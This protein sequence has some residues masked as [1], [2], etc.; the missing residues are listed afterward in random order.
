M[1]KRSLTESFNNAIEGL[2]YVVKTQRNMKIHLL[3]G[4]AVL[5]ISLFFNLTRLELVAI[6]FAIMLVIATELLNTAIEATIDM[7]TEDHH[8]FARV[9]KDVSAAAVLFAAINA[10]FT[11]YL[12]FF[13]RLTHTSLIVMEK[14]KQSPTYLT[15]IALAVASILVV[16]AKAWGGSKSYL[17]GGWPSGHS[18]LAGVLFTA[19]FLLSN[20]FLLGSLGFVLA[21]LVFESRIEANFHSWF[22]VISGALLGILVTLLLFKLFYF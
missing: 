5:L 18:A 12:I 13:N 14:I 22:E 1:K 9:A 4:L 20:D 8:D 3:V 11:G 7:I 10:V 19:L 16:S 17:R 15:S 2:V 6:F 21:L